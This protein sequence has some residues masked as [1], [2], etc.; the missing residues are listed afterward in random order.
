M[1]IV[2][3]VKELSINIEDDE[4]YK[5]LEESLEL[6][7]KMVESGQLVPRENQVQ[8]IYVPFEFNSNYS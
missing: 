7:H 4:N 3:Q 6:Y 5:E 1:S 2:E 8:S